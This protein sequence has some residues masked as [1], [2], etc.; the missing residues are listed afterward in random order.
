MRNFSW[1]ERGSAAVDA[2]D[3]LAAKDC[4]LRAVKS[5]TRN[6][7]H[8]FHLAVVLKGLGDIDAAAAA[9]TEALRLDPA[10]VDAAC[11][12]SSWASQYAVSDGAP[13][14][15]VGLCAA[16]HYDTVDREVIAELA[17]CHLARREPLR[18]A[19]A[20]GR[21]QGWLAAARSLCL[22]RT[23]QVLQND[24]L[25]EAL[26]SVFRHPDT[27]RLLTAL[28]RVLVVE[29]PPAR[30]ADRELIRFAV[31]LMQHC[32]ANEFVWA[33][34]EEEERVIAS[35]TIAIPRLL[36]GDF[37]EGRK[38]LLSALYRPLLEILDSQLSANDLSKVMP[39]A[40]REAVALRLA[41]QM[42]EGARGAKMP[43]LGA[44]ADETSRKVAQHYETSP[45]PRWTSLTLPQQNS[46]QQALGKYFSPGQLRFLDHPFE[47]LIAG[48]GTGQQAIRAALAYGRKAHVLGLDLSATSLAYAARMAAHFGA[49]NLAFMQGDIQR[50]DREKA[51]L[52]RFQVIECTGVLHHM[53]DP[54]Q[55]WRTLLKCLAPGGLMSV[56][57]YSAVSRRNLAALRDEPNY[58]GA[59]C[60]DNALR[61]F[62]QTLLERPDHAPGS[63]LKISR[64]FYTTSNFRDLV[65]HVSERPVTIPEIGQFLSDNGVVFKGFQLAPESFRLFQERFPGETWPGG[66]KSWAQFEDEHP[67]LFDGMYNFWCT[68]A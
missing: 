57:L 25:R 30:F 42:D 51:Y 61:A 7:R 43:S 26:G 23:G 32:W 58:P 34:S 3:L 18:S 10:M 36:G 49:S 4:F 45:Y 50:L 54:F 55:G 48:C 62:R 65:L 31:A 27:E 9:L 56:G 1:S 67:R 35:H 52:S 21:E 24:L 64:D 53:A 44:A 68:R 2:G 63:E 8:R 66:L 19:L 22:K 39:T 40:L 33:V 13:L 16:L 29:T 28:R 5:E 6:A 59:G 20:I 14:N 60:D 12:L 17:I 37:E 11:R 15:A 47:A 41:D 46:L 38:L